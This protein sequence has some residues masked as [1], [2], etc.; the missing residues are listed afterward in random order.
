MPDYS[1]HQRKI[2]ER[3]YDQ[4]DVI[5]LNKLSEIVT[6]LYLETS[7]K[8]L[9]SLWG[10]AKKAMVNLKVP[11]GIIEH[12]CEKRNAAVLARHVRDW[13]AQAERNR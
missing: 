6:E 2:I 13:T 1:P 5:M 4:R 12:L 3:Y 9:A 7:E 10:R 8:K 11:P